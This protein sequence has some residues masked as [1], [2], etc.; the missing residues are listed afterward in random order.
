MFINWNCGV[1]AE[2]VDSVLDVVRKE[3]ES[4]DCLQVDTPLPPLILAYKMLNKEP[5]DLPLFVFFSSSFALHVSSLF[6]LV[7]FFL[8]RVLLFPSTFFPL[9]FFFL[10]VLFSLYNPLFLFSIN[11]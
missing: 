7:F 4:C 5:Q 10:F 11:M 3:A 6:S 2:L 9:L 1:G 8:A